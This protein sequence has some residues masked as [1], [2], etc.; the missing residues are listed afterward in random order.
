MNVRHAFLAVLLNLATG[1]LAGAAPPDVAQPIP[2]APQSASPSSVATA[3]LGA[4]NATPT[5]VEPAAA[6][7][8]ATGYSAA[9]LYNLGNSYARAG[10]AGMAVL[11]YER[12]RLL[13]PGDADIDANLRHVREAA[14]LPPTPPRWFDPLGRIASPTVLAWTGVLGIAI[15]GM[16]MLLGQRH[17]R[18]RWLRRI[19]VPL[20]L[21]L[22]ALTAASG[23]VLWPL[24]HEAVV[25]TAATPVRVT[26][27]PMG[28]PLFTLPLAD[29][30]QVTGTH[31]EFVLIETRTGRTGWVAR[32]NLAPVIP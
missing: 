28:D 11:N 5:T 24:V 25:L 3:A 19:G 14:K 6:A 27:V 7:G 29:T 21:A 23:A 20:G 26:P 13:E 32:A 31:D 9:A 18:Y 16:G 8:P 12:A 30:V 4:I 17:V 2:T 10:N 15:A 22:L 1:G